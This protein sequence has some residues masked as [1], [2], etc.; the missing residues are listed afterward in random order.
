MTRAV[1]A[2]RSMANIL[3]REE[4]AR[5]SGRW[6]NWVWHNVDNRHRGSGGWASEARRAAE[7][8]VFIVMMRE[9]DAGVWG[10]L[11]HAWVRTAS[12]AVDLTWAEKQRI[13][14]EVFGRERVA[15]EVFPPRSELVDASNLFHLW[16]FPIGF[17]LPFTLKD[18]TEAP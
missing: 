16:V 9:T 13:K 2:G 18:R 17:Q 4:S 3:H 12:E 6:P 10:P 8:G 1:N 14:D 7:N 5:L 15:V 11:T